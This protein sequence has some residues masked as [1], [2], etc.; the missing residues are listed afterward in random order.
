MINSPGELCRPM[1]APAVPQGP[2]ATIEPLPP[3]SDSFLTALTTL[4][5]LDEVAKALPPAVWI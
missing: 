2:V 4:E 1:F 3:H 5:T